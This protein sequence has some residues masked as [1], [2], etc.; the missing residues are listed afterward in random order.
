MTFL[1]GIVSDCLPFLLLVLAVFCDPDLFC[2]F[3]PELLV[4]FEAIFL[5]FPFIR[6]AKFFFC[7]LLLSLVLASR[8][9]TNIYDDIAHTKRRK[10]FKPF[11]FP[12]LFSF[13]ILL[14]TFF[15]CHM[16]GIQLQALLFQKDGKSPPKQY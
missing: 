2:L 7:V 9:K 15:V 3:R 1:P 4:N 6:K 13:V 12:D 5:I 11:K 16:E 10:V 14:F 8:L